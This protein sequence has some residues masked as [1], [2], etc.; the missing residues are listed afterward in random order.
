MLRIGCLSIYIRVPDFAYW[1]LGKALSGLRIFQLN[2]DVGFRKCPRKYED[3]NHT[4]T[5][6]QLIKVFWSG[7]NEIQLVE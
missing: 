4:R 2:T 1:E 6:K 5:P 7:K 3:S